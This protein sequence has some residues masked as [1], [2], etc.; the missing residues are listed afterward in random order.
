MNTF[1]NRPWS[2]WVAQYER[3]HQNPINRLTHTIGIP[4]VAVSVV[5]LLLSLF[6]SGL[7]RIGL[8]VFIV[9]WIFQFVGHF[10]EGKRPE[11]F[12]DWRFLFVGLRW[13]WLKIS[14]KV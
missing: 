6:V 9:G 2:D 11:F 8:A 14:G 5:V 10:F 13:W 4:L 1:F 7:W 3:S 12:N